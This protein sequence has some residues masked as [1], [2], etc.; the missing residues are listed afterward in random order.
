MSDDIFEVLA[1]T[2]ELWSDAMDDH[3]CDVCGQPVHPDIA[4][5]GHIE[6][7]AHYQ[8]SDAECDMGCNLF[9]H[10]DCCPECNGNEDADDS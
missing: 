9:Y 5:W 4:H 2:P 3:I 1:N 7:C 8:D 6:E 10:P